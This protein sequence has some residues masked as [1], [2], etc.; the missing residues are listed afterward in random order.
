MALMKIGSKVIGDGLDALMFAEE[1]QANQGDI[2]V[3][4]SCGGG[5]VGGSDADI[6]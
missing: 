1:G 2:N 4:I 3:A 5:S 6:G